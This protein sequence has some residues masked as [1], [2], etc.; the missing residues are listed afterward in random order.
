MITVT[1]VELA[2]FAEKYDWIVIE[3]DDDAHRYLTPSG[4]RVVVEFAAKDGSILRV[5]P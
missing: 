1:A 5:Y 2:K 3:R 4:Q